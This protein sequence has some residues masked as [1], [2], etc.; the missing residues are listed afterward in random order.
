MPW[1]LFA[2]YSPRLS[3][4]C[5]LALCLSTGLLRVRIS[6]W[7]SDREVFSVGSY[8]FFGLKGFLWSLRCLVFRVVLKGFFGEK[9]G[10]ITTFV[11]ASLVGVFV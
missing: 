4:A 6:R 11:E 5:S 9:R 2:C 1:V 3:V 7:D 10:K 8:N